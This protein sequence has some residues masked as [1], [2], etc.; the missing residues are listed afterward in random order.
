M[1]YESNLFITQ[2]PHR[3]EDGEP[4]NAYDGVAYCRHIAE[5]DLCKVGDDND[6]AK[7]FID[8]IEAERARIEVE[9]WRHGVY[10]LADGNTQ[11]TDD[12]YGDPVS[13][14]PLA[15]LIEALIGVMRH[16]HYR[17]YAPLLAM[18]QAFSVQ[19]VA[20]EWGANGIVVLHY[21]H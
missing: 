19:A 14:V 7:L 9:G 21:G 12:K 20:G 5:F 8:S 17:R 11:H 2:A 6:L 4:T 1:G 16:D 13:P 3:N 15:R 18:L 10:E